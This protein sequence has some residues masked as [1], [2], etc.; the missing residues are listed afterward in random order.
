MYK[1]IQ[2]DVKVHVKSHVG[3]HRD[4]SC[5]NRIASSTEASS[6]LSEIADSKYK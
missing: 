4:P 1:N 5:Y 3:M 2:S 6:V